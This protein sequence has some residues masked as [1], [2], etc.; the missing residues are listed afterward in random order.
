M[1][2]KILALLCICI[3]L[4]SCDTIIAS[5]EDKMEATTPR[6][7]SISRMDGEN[8]LTKVRVVEVGYSSLQG[9]TFF[10][11]EVMGSNPAKVIRVNTTPCF[12]PTEPIN[13][14][15]TITI[16]VNMC[17]ICTDGANYWFPNCE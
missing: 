1:K 9:A 12:K 16:L 10:K 3:T 15:D 7:D 5:S 4:Y 14:T 6:F 13:V 8:Y 17:S 2:T 11:C